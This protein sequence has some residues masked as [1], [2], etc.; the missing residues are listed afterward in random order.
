M[1]KSH[2][3]ALATQTSWSVRTKCARFM[4]A[5]QGSLTGV[6]AGLP[7]PVRYN[8]LEA[9]LDTVHGI[10]STRK[11]AIMKLSRYHNHVRVSYFWLRGFTS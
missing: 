7:S 10:S 5:L 2:F 1:Y 11:D 8:D 9:R 3:E 6:V 4:D